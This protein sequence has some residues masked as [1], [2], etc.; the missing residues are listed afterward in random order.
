M[1]SLGPGACAVVQQLD[2]CRGTCGLGASLGRSRGLVLLPSATLL[3]STPACPMQR[4]GCSRP[5]RTAGSALWQLCPQASCPSVP[6]GDGVRGSEPGA[7]ALTP[8]FRLTEA[9]RGSGC[10]LRGDLVSSPCGAA[11]EAGWAGQSLC[12]AYMPGPGLS[13][14]LPHGLLRCCGFGFGAG[15]GL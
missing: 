13:T 10:G 6:E 15:S 4:G 14:A 9:I 8:G 1:L 5:S 2:F 11:A 7:W 12:L 3:S